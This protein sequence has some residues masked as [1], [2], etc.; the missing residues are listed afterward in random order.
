MREEIVAL[1]HHADA[2]ALAGKLA[3]GQAMAPAAASD[4]VAERLAVEPDLAALELLEEIDAAQQRRLARA[5]RAD[6]RH[7]VARKDVEVDAA[8]DRCVSERLRQ[9]PDGQDGFHAAPSAQPEAALE[10]PAAR[11]RW[12]G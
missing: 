4:A 10:P 7:D 8:Q 12:R 2:G 5:A 6:D 11:R 1:E 3:A 9:A